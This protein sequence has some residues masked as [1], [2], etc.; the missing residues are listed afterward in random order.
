MDRRNQTIKTRT[1]T[2][3]LCFLTKT[4]FLSQ[5]FNRVNGFNGAKNDTPHTQNT[6]KQGL[7]GYCTEV[8][9]VS[10]EVNSDE[11]TVK[12]T[13][14]PYK[15]ELTEVTEVTEGKTERGRQ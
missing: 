3:N 1:N 15:T 14:F 2:N 11:K 6:E 13:V 4:F 5:N 10:T 9:E 12:P 8:T 7:T